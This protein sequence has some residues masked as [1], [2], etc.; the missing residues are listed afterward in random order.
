VASS[1]SARTRVDSGTRSAHPKPR[2][3]PER[4]DRHDEAG[5]LDRSTD[6][7]RRC[8][9]VPVWLVVGDDGDRRSAALAQGRSAALVDEQ[10]LDCGREKEAEA[11]AELNRLL[12]ALDGHLAAIDERLRAVDEIQ[13]AIQRNR[14]YLAGA[15][16]ELSEEAML[17]LQQHMER[18]SKVVETLSNILKKAADTAWAITQNLK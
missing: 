2:H 8:V 12:E 9:G 4:R 13:G 15:D 10:A 11:C 3:S 5:T 16:N 1:F 7:R 6:S 14:F 18:R 17:R